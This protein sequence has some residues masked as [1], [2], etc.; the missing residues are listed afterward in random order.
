[1]GGSGGIRNSYKV[2]A[3]KS[4]GICLFGRP[5]RTWKNYTKMDIENMLLDIGFRLS[6]LRIWSDGGLL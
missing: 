5:A 3:T 1:M 6:W 2:L 4:D